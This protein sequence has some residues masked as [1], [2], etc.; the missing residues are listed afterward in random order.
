MNYLP[1]R[2]AVGFARGA[3]FGVAVASTVSAA[4]PE[5]APVVLT[6]CSSGL[7]I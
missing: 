1:S 6:M 2:E 4:I 7:T 3:A 5:A